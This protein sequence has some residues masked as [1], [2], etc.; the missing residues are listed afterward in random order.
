[1]Q[2]APANNIRVGQKIWFESEIFATGKS[3]ERDIGGGRTVWVRQYSGEVLGISGW[4]RN[5][6]RFSV[7]DDG[8]ETFQL[9]VPIS[10]TALGYVLRAR[11]YML[12]YQLVDTLPP[13]P[14]D[15]R[16]E[17]QVRRV[18][19]SLSAHHQQARMVQS[20]ELV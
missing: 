9:W 18:G 4:E 17:G 2:K 14:M 16:K 12:R 5:W 13:P 19:S 20:L 10:W 8:Q 6:V 11:H 1:M 3:V 7:G 15:G